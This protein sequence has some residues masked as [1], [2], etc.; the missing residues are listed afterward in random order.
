[1]TDGPSVAES[2]SCDDD[3]DS[4]TD[5]MS[6]LSVATGSTITINTALSNNKLSDNK[7]SSAVQNLVINPSALSAIQSQVS[8]LNV[9]LS[10]VIDCTTIEQHIKLGELANVTSQTGSWCFPT[11]L[12]LSA[13]HTFHSLLCPSQDPYYLDL[14]QKYW[15]SLLL[16]M[17]RC[18]MP[19]SLPGMNIFN[20]LPCIMPMQCNVK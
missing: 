19:N 2:I 4:I 3:S 13:F 8:I 20:L 14:L 11:I 10:Q 17:L 12:A 5:T 15:S 7:K 18:T 9:Q 1:M 16:W 6:V